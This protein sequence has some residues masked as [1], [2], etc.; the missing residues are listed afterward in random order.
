MVKEMY[1]YIDHRGN[2][3]TI[4]GKDGFM[5]IARKQA[6]YLSLHSVAV[7]PGDDFDIDFAEGKIL[8]HR[9]GG[10]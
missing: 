10:Q 8:K 1:A 9:M 3:T 5:K 6:G 7:Y 2:L 4:V